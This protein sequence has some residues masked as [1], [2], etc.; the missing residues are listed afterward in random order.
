MNVARRATNTIL[1]LSGIEHNRDRVVTT[2]FP[3]PSHCCHACDGQEPAFL[4][5]SICSACFNSFVGKVVGHIANMFSWSWWCWRSLTRSVLRGSWNNFVSSLNWRAICIRNLLVSS[6]ARSA[7]HSGAEYLLGFRGS[8][9][10]M[11]RSFKAQ[12]FDGLGY[13]YAIL[14]N[15]RI[16]EVF[17]VVWASPF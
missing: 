11:G 17:A 15:V 13:L 14:F 2:P 16:F 12:S 10:Q 7:C 4:M 5:R 3:F 1:A 9:C 6:I 8:A